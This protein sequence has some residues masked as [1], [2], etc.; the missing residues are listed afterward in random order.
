MEERKGERVR[1]Y[2]EVERV[3]HCDVEVVAGRSD[4]ESTVR[5]VSGEGVEYDD[6]M[7]LSQVSPISQDSM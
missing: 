7:D 6:A 3:E 1:A 2:R 4:E 5:R